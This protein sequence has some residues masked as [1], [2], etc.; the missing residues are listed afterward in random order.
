MACSATKARV[1]IAIDKSN[2]DKSGDTQT[3]TK[4]GTATFTIRVMNSGDDV[5]TNVVIDDPLAPECSRSAAQTAKLYGATFDP[6]RSFSATC[7]QTNVQKSYTN[8]ATATAT[9]TDGKTKLCM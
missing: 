4:G 3:V 1:A 8:L 6:K 5:L 7:T 9:T 2:G